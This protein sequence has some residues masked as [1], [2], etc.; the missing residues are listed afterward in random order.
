MD[1]RAQESIVNQYFRDLKKEVNIVSFPHIDICDKIYLT[2][3][4]VS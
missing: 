1:V 2:W 4:T 3:L